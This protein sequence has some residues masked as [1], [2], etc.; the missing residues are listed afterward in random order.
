MIRAAVLGADVTKSRSPAIHRAAFRA[1]GV[2][3]TYEALSVGEGGGGA[4]VGDRDVEVPEAARAQLLDEV[5]EAGLVDAERLV[6][7]AD[8]ERAEGAGVPPKAGS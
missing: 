1:L 7:A 2:R 3:G 4:L 8:A 5:A 6:G